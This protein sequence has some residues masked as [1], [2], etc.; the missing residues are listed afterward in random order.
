MAQPKVMSG[1]PRFARTVSVNPGSM[2][3]GTSLVVTVTV[4]GLKKGVP[5]IV[6]PDTTYEFD[7]VRIVSAYVKANNTLE[8]TFYNFGGNTRDQAAF[9]LQVIGF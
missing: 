6:F 4:T 9:N 5:V 1:A 8:L 7:D 3:T 2:A